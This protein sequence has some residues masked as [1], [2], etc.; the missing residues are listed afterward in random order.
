VARGARLPR[1]D[2]ARLAV[3][4][5]AAANAAFAKAQPQTL[6]LLKRDEA[7]AREWMSLFAGGLGAPDDAAEDWQK[8]REEMQIG[9][10]DCSGSSRA[11]AAASQALA[12]RVRHRNGHACRRQKL[13]HRGRH[14]SSYG[15]YEDET[16]LKCHAQ[17]ALKPAADGWLTGAV[18][19]DAESF[20]ETPAGNLE[21]P[22]C[23]RRISAATSQSQASKYSIFLHPGQTR[24]DTHHTG[25]TRDELLQLQRERIAMLEDFRREACRT[26]GPMARL[27]RA[28]PDQART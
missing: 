1:W 24:D 16:T 17:A 10:R 26:R 14:R 5:D 11:A 6:P 18:L 3:A 7:W 12:K 4:I 25:S 27:K 9:S 20:R 19:A 8:L 15:G 28:D 23:S 13:S 21:P 2:A 22:H